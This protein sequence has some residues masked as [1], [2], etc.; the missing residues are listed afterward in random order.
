MKNLFVGNLD[1]EDA[2]GAS[3][4]VRSLRTGGCRFISLW[5]VTLGCRAGLH[6]WK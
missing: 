4:A 3:A 1:P 5:I 2:R 6:S